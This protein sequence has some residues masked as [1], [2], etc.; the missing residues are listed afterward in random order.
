MT[1]QQYIRAWARRQDINERGFYAF[2]QTKLNIETK[3]YIKSLEGRNPNTFHITSF[4]SDK[5]MM[6]ILKDAYYKFGRKQNEFLNA[7]N[8]KAEEDEFNYAWDLAVLLLFKNILEFV[9]ILGIIRTIKNDIKRFVEDKSSQGIPASAIITLLALYL[10][11]KNIIRAQMIART[12]TTKIMNLASIEWANLE[13]KEIKK[14]WIVTLD[15]K[16]RASHSDMADYPAIGLSEKFIVG[17]F[18]MNA[19]GDNSAPASEL[20]N[21]RCGIMFI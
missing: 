6:E 12:E 2:L 20:V 14:K 7:T 17:G 15:G 4:F 13:R 8:K 18:P 9:V 10:T 1:E 16:E 19:P 3:A 21:C 5:W 11:Q